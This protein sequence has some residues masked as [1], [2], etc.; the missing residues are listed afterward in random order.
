MHNPY[1]IGNAIYLRSVEL[2]DGTTVAAWL[3]DPDVRRFLRG[4]LP[5]SRLAEEAFL[6]RISESEND[7]VLGI[8]VRQSDQLIGV[9][10]LHQLDNRNRHALFGITIGDKNAWNKG[11]GTEATE[12]VLRFAFRTLNLH[13]VWLH[14]YE[15]NER[16]Q[17]VYEKIGFRTEGRL[18]QDTF[19][20]GRYWDTIVMGLLR[21]E[22]R[23]TEGNE[24]R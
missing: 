11:Y 2:E 22:W 19:R 13:R 6:R 7:L 5:L 21:D 23:A 17:H 14:V 10:G 18:R 1:L 12:L 24:N 16:A 4:R 8:V 9:L 3:N 15:F 20:E